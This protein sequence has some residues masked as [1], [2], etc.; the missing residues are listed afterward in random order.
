MMSDKTLEQEIMEAVQRLD[1]TRKRQV[2]DYARDLT[3]RPKG[4][5]GKEFLERT[6]DIHID[7]ADLKLMEEAIEEAFEEPEDPFG[8][9]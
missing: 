4:I 5:S 7:P 6:R 2:L 3:A 8:R 1:T 9:G